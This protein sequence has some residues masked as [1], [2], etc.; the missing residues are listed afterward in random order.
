MAEDRRYKTNER[1]FSQQLRVINSKGE[2]IGVLSKAEALQMARAEKLDLVEISPKAV[3][4]VAKILDFKKFLYEEKKKSSAA[5]AKSKQV[6]V[7]EFK[8]GPNIGENDLTIRI[9]RARG[10]LAGRDKVKFA[11][12]FKGREAAFPQIGWDKINRV[13]S[14]LSDI[15]KPEEPPK[16]AHSKL[17]FVVMM[18]R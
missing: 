10:F 6:E 18:P 3:P 7:K 8:F 13:V 12:T 9:G 17:L 16:M 15:A 5:T 11:V 4:P 14:E 2:N 1:I